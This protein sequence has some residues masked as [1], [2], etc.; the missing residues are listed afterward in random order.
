MRI[1]QLVQKPQRRG[2]EVFAY[3]LSEQLVNDDH[4]VSTAYLYPCEGDASLPLKSADKVIGASP[5]HFSERT[6]GWNPKIVKAL[7]KM[8]KQFQPEVIQSNGARTVKYGAILRA[9][10]PRSSWVLIYRSI[11]DPKVWLKGRIRK[12]FYST[13]VIPRFDGIVAVSSTTLEGLKSFY[14]NI[15]RLITIPRGVRTS[16]FVPGRTKEAVRRELD[17]PESA[18]VMIVVGSL[19]FEKCVERNLAALDRLRTV[20]PNLYLWIIGDGPERKQL[21]KQMES[22]HLQDRVR[23][24]GQR[25]DVA[26]FVGASDLFV[27]LSDTEGIPGAVLEAGILGIPSVASR[28]GGVPECVINGKTGI[29]VDPGNIDEVSGSI[30]RMILDPD[31]RIRMGSEARSFIL[32]KFPMDKIAHAYAEFYQQILTSK[33]QNS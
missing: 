8:V 19:S 4:E 12:W 5:G 23:F 31:L 11:G 21:E 30:K 3:E 27:L 13:V 26:D 17:T 2:A 25:A 32:E 1:L 16:K 20:L 15:P 9:M 14:K 28:V 7:S 6:I 10:D 33:R 18:P 24:A 29:L 22:L